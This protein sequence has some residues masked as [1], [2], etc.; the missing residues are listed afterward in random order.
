MSNW[1]GVEHQPVCNMLFQTESLVFQSY[2][3]RW[4]VFWVGFLGS[5]YLQT[6]GVWKTSEYG[7]WSFEYKLSLYTYVYPIYGQIVSIQPLILW[8]YMIHIALHSCLVSVPTKN[9]I[10]RLWKSYVSSGHI[11][12]VI[13]CAIPEVWKNVWCIS[14]HLPPKL[15]KC[16]M[17]KSRYIGDGHTTF[18]RNPFNLYINPYY[19]VDDHPLLYGNNESLDPGTN[20]EK[21]SI[22]WVCG[23]GL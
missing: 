1:L 22:H 7:I 5:K 16:A 20:V 3:L 8:Y 19:W 11:T 14:L 12:L 6:Q 23:I 15:P 21:Y 13:C 4:K 9:V 10:E 17:V 18:N 2:L